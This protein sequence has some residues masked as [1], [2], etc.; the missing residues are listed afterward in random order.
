MNPASNSIKAGLPPTSE[1]L[2][3]PGK[4]YDLAVSLQPGKY[5]FQCDP[6]ALPGMMGHLEVEKE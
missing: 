3:L 5:F 2:Q 4:T 1:T 6:H